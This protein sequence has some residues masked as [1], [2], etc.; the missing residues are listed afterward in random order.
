M[1]KKRQKA[2]FLKRVTSALTQK[3]KNLTKRL[4][5][6]KMNVLSFSRF[7]RENEY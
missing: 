5:D 7:E 4:V 2:R 6:K 3:I 1:P